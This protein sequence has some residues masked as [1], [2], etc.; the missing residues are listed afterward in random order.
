M[1]ARNPSLARKVLIQMSIRITLIIVA[2]TMVSYWHLM[3]VLESQ[4]QEHLEKYV[5]E[6]G[7][8]E[9]S[10][11]LLAQDNLEVFKQEF[12]SRLTKMGEQDPQIEFNQ[13]VVEQKDGA[14]RSRKPLFDGTKEAGI[15][16]SDSRV[17]TPEL[18]RRT[19][20][21]YRLTTDFGIAWHDRFQDIYFVMPENII[22]IYWPEV[23]H[24]IYNVKI[25]YNIKEQEY[26]W[27]ADAQH[28][29]TRVTAWTGTYYDK[30]AMNWTASCMLPI[31]LNDQHIGTVGHDV[32]LG[33][34]VERTVN[35]HL[36][37]T[38][39]LIFR[40]DGRLIVHP[41]HVN[42]I[43]HSEGNFNISQANNPH[44]NRI[45]Q[46][47]TH[48]ADR[49]TVINNEIDKE[50]LAVTQLQ[51]TGWYFVTVYPKSLLV[52][53]AL[54]TAQFILLLG[55][56]SLLLEIAVLFFV[57]RKQVAQPLTEF[58]DAT[59]QIAKGHFNLQLQIS[60]Q[61]ELGKLACSL[62][63]MAHEIDIREEHLR[64]AKELAE[65]ASQAKTNFLANMSHELRTPLNGILG[66]AQIFE[67]SNNLTAT[68]QEGVKIIKQSGH[69]LL[70]LVNDIIDLS[71]IETEGI[72]L[73][74]IDFNFHEFLQELVEFFEIRAYQKGLVFFYEQSS[75]LPL[76][77]KADSKRLRQVLMNLLNNAV[78]FTEKGGVTFKVSSV[79]D[80]IQFHIQ[81]TGMGIASTDIDKLF[82]PFQ[83]IG[84]YMTKKASGI[85][86]SLYTTQRLVNEMAG[87]LIVESVEGAGSIFSVTLALPES[88]FIRS[89]T[90]EKTIILG[91]QGRQQTILVVDD[92]PENRSV[93]L[94][95]LT[96][97]GF[98]VVQAGH[99][100]EGVAKAREVHPDLILM[101]LVMPVMDGF[102]AVREI[103]KIL[104][105]EKVPI[106]AASASVLEIPSLEESQCTAFIL[107]PFR[108][109]ALLELLR[110]HLNLQWIYKR[111]EQ[112]TPRQ[113]VEKNEESISST[114]PIQVG[115]SVEQAH[116]LLELAMC[117]D[118]RG[119]LAN[120]KKL[121][122]THPQLLPFICRVRELAKNFEE[123]KICE[124]I[125]RYTR[126]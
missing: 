100:K 117:G 118:I 17:M 39:N 2:I 115:P 18:R 105:L 113:H 25:D 123:E 15:F 21:A 22:T 29:P 36:Q 49:I 16:I 69:Y 104:S 37:G 67:R 96:P 72:E 84:H 81:D 27:V 79:E 6:R 45:F 14:I 66:Y 50:Y 103:R 35:D 101:D 42:D 93:I 1:S 41:N 74:P 53:L 97:L 95:L 51:S 7:L 43:R 80:K 11:F 75:P 124:L 88:E 94:H 109:E 83:Q 33:E 52:N 9:S 71:Q 58:M 120:L 90:S 24:W 112:K 56:L 91:Y 32:L 76:G 89:T 78:K 107:K 48:Q 5:I 64:H 119:I 68:Q 10:V 116:I 54:E 8:R 110:I 87:S 59:E 126:S 44:L 125:D 20:V 40:Q 31:Y 85:G 19:L 12:L 86:L 26:Y 65:V 77:V 92:S 73:H 23:P 99:G 111:H 122:E 13:L 57:L 70:T 47:V 38:Y 30:V 46:L 3:L 60:G 102:A 62:N 108:A 34:L 28:N 82:I 121:E 61:D 55:V 98:H 63:I 4:T 114:Q 106:I